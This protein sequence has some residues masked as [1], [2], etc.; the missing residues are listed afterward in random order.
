MDVTE[1]VVTVEVVVISVDTLWELK[2]WDV[3]VLDTS[4]EELWELIEV[5]VG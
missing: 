2:V 1:V 5:A 3:D 4:V